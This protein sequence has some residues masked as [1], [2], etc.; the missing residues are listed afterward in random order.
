MGRERRGLGK[1]NWEEELG[2]GMWKRNGEELGE[3]TTEDDW[4]EKTEDY[5]SG[6]G[7]K[8]PRSV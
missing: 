6:L 2:K 7:I 5:E 1:R 8:T 4:G 3:R